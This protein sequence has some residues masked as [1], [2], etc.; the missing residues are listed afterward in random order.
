MATRL[1]SAP[2]ESRSERGYRPR[3][4]ITSDICIPIRMKIR[5]FSMNTMKF[6]TERAMILIFAET[7]SGEYLPRTSPAATTARTPDTWSDSA[8]I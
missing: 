1:I 5:L 7:I 4:S 8:A 6:Q 3:L 2:S